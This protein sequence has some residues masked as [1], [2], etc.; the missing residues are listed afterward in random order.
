MRVSVSRGRLLTVAVTIVLLFSIAVLSSTGYCATPPKDVIKIRFSY[1]YA[2]DHYSALMS[3]K[4]AK[5]INEETKGRVQITTFG[6]A[7]LY[8]STQI[9]GAL[10]KEWW[11]W[12]PSITRNWYHSAPIS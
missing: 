12:V 4:Y 3:E 6:N 8:N 1:Q 9:A 7:T 2:L 5:M 10:G 11:R